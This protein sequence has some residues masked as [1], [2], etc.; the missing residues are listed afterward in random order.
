MSKIPPGDPIIEYFDTEHITGAIG[1]RTVRGGAITI[2]SHGLKFMMSIVATAVLARLLTPQDYG[3]IGMVAVITSFVSMFKDLGLSLATVQRPEISYDQI[4]TLFWVNVTLSAGITGLMMLLAPGVAWFYGEP[5]LTLITVLTSVGF[6]FGGLAVQHE[7]LLK[8]QMRFYA[9]SAVAFSS[10]MIGYAA[11][12]LAAWYGARYWALVAGQ[13]A[14]LASNAIGVWTV[15]RWRPGKP[16]RNA[17]VKSMLSFGGNITGYALINY[18]S[19]NSDN[20]LIGKLFGPQPLGLYGKSAQ[21]L[22]LPTDQINEPLSTV[23]IPALSRLANAPNRY[24]QAYLRIM[25][26]VIM[27]TMPAVV[28][29]IATSD[30]LVQIVLG[31]QW[32]EASRIFVFMGIAGLFQPVASTGGWLLVTQGRGR[33]MLRWSII[34]APISILSIILG[35]HWGVLGVA[36]GFSFGRI[37]IANPLLFWFVGRSGPV[38]TGDFYRLLAPFTLAAAASLLVCIVI[39]SSFAISNAVFGMGICALIVAV[40]TIATLALLPGGRRALFDVK[41]SISL[42]RRG[43]PKFAAGLT[44]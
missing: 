13:L 36:A 37:L 34:N 14:L 9:L 1:G 30:W 11:G 43:D 40:T 3:L 38:R 25:E 18:F 35:L 10:M 26:K 8:R 44:E 20:L 39:R 23:A 4:S 42:L 16:R 7:A 27:L 24:R 32:H 31:S 33:D 29:M 2:L 22:S 6:L 41:H 21:L 5:R 15:C 19:K 12:I 17:G 28:L